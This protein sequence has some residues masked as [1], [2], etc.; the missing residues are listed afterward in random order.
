MFIVFFYLK[1]KDKRVVDITVVNE[2]G[3]GMRQNQSFAVALRLLFPS[4]TL[5]A[6]K[7]GWIYEMW[8]NRLGA[9]IT[10]LFCYGVQHCSN[11]AKWQDNFFPGCHWLTVFKS[12][13]LTVFVIINFFFI[14]SVNFTH[15]RLIRIVSVSAHRTEQC[16]M[17]DQIS[18][19]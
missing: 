11:S 7:L 14:F 5:I 13:A 4:T 8:G 9:V 18:S 19:D 6:L 12:P 17:A 16:N 3:N 10:W 2:N 15:I 1:W